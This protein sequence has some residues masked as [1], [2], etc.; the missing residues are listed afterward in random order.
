[1]R[2]LYLCLAALL[3]I[4][5]LRAA[6]NL[7]EALTWSREELARSPLELCSPTVESNFRKI[8]FPLHF[9]HC[10]YLSFD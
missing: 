3:T 6:E 7:V 8:T 2:R 4:A 5:E 10:F 1:M 9:L